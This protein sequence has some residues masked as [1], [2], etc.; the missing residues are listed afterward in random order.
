MTSVPSGRQLDR[1]FAESVVLRVKTMA[2][3][4]RGPRNRLTPTGRSRVRAAG[5]TLTWPL[6]SAQH[7]GRRAD[8]L[9]QPGHRPRCPS[10]V[11]RPGEELVHDRLRIDEHPR[12]GDPAVAHMADPRF[13]PFRATA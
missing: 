7:A 12:V 4:A 10:A 9:V 2:S 3:S 11:G 6:W 13:A 8:R 1:R 5:P